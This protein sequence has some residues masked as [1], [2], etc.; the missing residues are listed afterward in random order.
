MRVAIAIPRFSHDRYIVVLP[1]SI[2]TLAYPDGETTVTSSRS[3]DETL[4][5][6]GRNGCE[7]A[8]VDQAKIA[9]G[10]TLSIGCELEAADILAC[11]NGHCVPRDTDWLSRLLRPILEGVVINGSGYEIGLDTARTCERRL[12]DKY[13]A[14][15]REFE[16]EVLLQE[17]RCGYRPQD[18]VSLSIRQRR[19]RS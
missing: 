19:D 17:N 8:L 13:Y 15:L 11:V 14:L 3:T 7:I 2:V 16:G 6:A 9:F 10:L 4:S 1:Q 5:I 12:F 18:L